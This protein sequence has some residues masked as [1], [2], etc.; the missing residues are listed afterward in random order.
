MKLLFDE[1]LSPR[2]AKQL[3]DSFPGSSHVH[4][5]GL[6]SADDRVVFAHARTHEFVVV[7]K[8]S[9]FADLAFALGSPPKVIWLRIGNCSTAT[10]AALLLRHRDGIAEFGADAEASI[11]ALADDEG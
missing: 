7:T 10:I 8:D 11:L 3:Q 2:L 4:D 5:L 1:Q 9:D 6:G